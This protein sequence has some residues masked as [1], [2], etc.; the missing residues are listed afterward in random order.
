MDD[1]WWVR[2]S[3]LDEEQKDV[4]TLSIQED[5][6]ITGP[7]GSGKTN[8]LLLR[9]K[10]LIGSNYPNV[11]VVVHTRTLQEFI[12]SGAPS[13]GVPAN[14][15]STFRKLGTDLLYQCGV[16]INLPSDFD[17]A[18]QM[19]AEALWNQIAAGKLKDAYTYM[20][21]DEAQDFLPEEM[22]VLCNL[23][24]RFFAV[25][26]SRQ[27]IYRG[28]DSIAML[29]RE[30]KVVNLR[31]HYRNGHKICT[32]ADGLSKFPAEGPTFLE[33]S[34]YDE[35]RLVSSVDI[36]PS[37]SLDQQCAELVARLDTQ[38]KA[39]PQQ[40][41]GVVCPRGEDLAAVIVFLRHSSVAQHIIAQTSDE[42]YVQFD[43]DKL[44]CASKLH[45]A[46][47]LEFRAFHILAAEGLKK[48]PLQRE[49][50]FMGITRAKTSLCIYHNDDLPGY[51]EGALS[52]LEP[53]KPPLGLRDL[54]GGKD[55]EETDEEI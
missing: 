21:I 26:D 38:L 28:Q 12:R 3:Q 24:N 8:L 11:V 48:F 19:L 4:F 1:T 29:E 34:R 9:A 33:T 31:F 7:P 32:V 17:R 44:I 47:G 10:Q 53:P 49:L 41:I 55:N 43:P 39:Y 15:I 6:F 52:K 2:E 40:M 45:S 54:L 30:A 50:S 14:K 23:G 5:H 27:K 16:S 36:V 35:L 18:R 22:K 13:Y 51:L 37:R 42:G 46:K 25:A 20:L